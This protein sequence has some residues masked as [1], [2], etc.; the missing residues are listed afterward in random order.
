MAS[1]TEPSGPGLSASLRDISRQLVGAR[2]AGTALAGPPGEWPASADDAYALQAHSIA[3]WDDRV[4]GWKVGGVPSERRASF[5]ADYVAGPIFAASVRYADGI[6]ST[7]MPIFDGGFA[8]IEPEFVFELGEDRDGDRLFIGLEIASSP[9]PDLNDYGPTAVV[10]DF[11]NNF[12]LLV[13]PE[14]AD[15]RDRR[16]PVPV[17]CTI[18]G[19]EVGAKKADFTGALASLQFLIDLA[20]MRGFDLPAGTFVSSGAITGVHEAEC[21]ARSVTSFGEF[22]SLAI[23][24]VSAAPR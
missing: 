1:M 6:G 21:G 23:E 5:G 15:W 24:L 3:G 2:A 22:G 9:V 10:S 8:A 19:Q 7:A 14:I 11:G 17:V 12:G 13:G 20:E 18:D 4:A 16:E